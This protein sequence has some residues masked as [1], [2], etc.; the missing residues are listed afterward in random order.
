MRFANRADA[1]TRLAA[2]LRTSGVL[3]ESAPGTV[4]A[5]G[6]PRGG[7]PVAYEVAAVF[8]VPLDVI[9]VRKIGVPRQPELAMGAIGE[10]GVRVANRD[11]MRAAGV[12]RA[13]FERI[14][15]RERVELERRAAILRDARPAL[16]LTGHTGII[17]D[18]GIATGSTARVA[19]IVGRALGLER[20][21][22]AA[23][24]APPSTVGALADVAD[25][26][27]VVAQP[28]RFFAIGEF[29]NDFTAT[30]E[31][32]VIALLRRARGVTNR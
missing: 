3:A 4:V 13:E 24:V 21:I 5:L 19:C 12:S 20:V 7:V 1:G 29:Y 26:V 2:V 22:L 31:D 9:L 32:E 23:P 25:R 16:T 8:G 10:S 27:I 30:R 14:E 18:D 11:V 6:L 15:A 17:V 28:S